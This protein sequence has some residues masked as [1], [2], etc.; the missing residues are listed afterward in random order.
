[1]RSWDSC[2]GQSPNRMVMILAGTTT[3][4]TQGVVEFVCRPDS[5]EKLLHANEIAGSEDRE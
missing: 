2:R 5:V 3:F 1:M 4:G